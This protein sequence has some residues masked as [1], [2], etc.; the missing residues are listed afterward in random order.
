MFLSRLWKRSTSSVG[1]VRGMEGGMAGK[2]EG[3]K[4]RRE[5]DKGKKM[6]ER[7]NEFHLES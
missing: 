2:K 4:G 7:M 5:G 1:I 3:G 6:E